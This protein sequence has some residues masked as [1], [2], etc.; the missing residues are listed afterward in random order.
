MGYIHLVSLKRSRQLCDYPD[1]EAVRE[2]FVSASLST[3]RLLLVSAFPGSFSTCSSS[4]L[5]ARLHH[6][7]IACIHERYLPAVKLRVPV[8]LAEVWISLIPHALL[9]IYIRVRGIGLTQLVD[10][11]LGA[12]KVGL[13]RMSQV[14]KTPRTRPSIHIQ[15]VSPSDPMGMNR[16]LTAVGC[17]CLR[18]ERSVQGRKITICEA[19][20]TRCGHS[21]DSAK[22]RHVRLSL[23]M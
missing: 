10:C 18:I 23:A 8:R 3:L 14:L 16:P 22:L 13:S 12:R 20:P 5:S 6:D 21:C 15:Q 7:P 17:P 19:H 11:A 9:K 2:S 1:F 4:D